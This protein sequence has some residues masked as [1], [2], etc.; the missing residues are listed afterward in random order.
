MIIPIEKVVPEKKIIILSPHYDDIPLTFGGY[1]GALIK[2]QLIR[3]KEIRIIQIFTFSNYLLRDEKG[4]K[5]IS[6]ER[7]RHVTG[8][9]LS[10]DIQCLDEML[11]HSNYRYEIMR[12]K[13]CLLRQK[14]LVPAEE[15]E[16]FEFLA[17]NKNNFNSFDWEVYER[18][19]KSARRWL[20]SED[21]ALLLVMAIREHIDHV[22]VRDA[23][24]DTCKEM[25]G[26]AKATVYLGED[27][28]YAGL[29]GEED[30]KKANDFLAGWQVTPIDYGIELDRKVGMVMR[31]Y[32]S[33]AEESYRDGMIRRSEKLQKAENNE[34]GIE[35]MYRVD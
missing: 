31:N 33:Q 13:E 3:K 5:D 12:E 17:G 34:S 7:I 6:P 14:E 29:A 20:L 21:T 22:I 30:W 23:V 24:M 27:Q 11:G 15:N 25:G 18:L 16:E 10:E 26:E 1:L 8:I 9:R 28:P 32:V 4:N 2:H 19:K 35:R